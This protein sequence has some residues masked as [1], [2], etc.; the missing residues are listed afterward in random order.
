MK[1]LFTPCGI[2]MGHVSRSIA[3]SKELKKNKIETEFASYGSGYEILSEYYGYKTTKLPDIKFYGVNGELD[4]KNTVKKSIDMPYTFL[5]S[6]YQE[7]KVIK[8]FKPDLIIAD[9]QYSIPITAKIHDVPCI[10]ITNE[11]TVNFSEI[12]PNEKK[13]EYIEYGLDKFIK[14]VCNQCQMIMIPD[15]EGSTVVPLKLENKV[16]HIGPFLSKDPKK[17]GD[18]KDLKNQFGLKQSDKIVLV[19]VGGSEFGIELLKLIYS[20]SNQIKSDK[21]IIVT[22]PKLEVDFIEESEKI[23][24]KKFLQDMMEWMKI[25]DVI[26]SLAGQ[27][28]LMEIL[29]LGIPNVVV[30]IDNHP[31]QIKNSLKVGEY[32]ISIVEDIKKLNSKKL[33]HDI[34]HLLSDPKVAERSE[35]VKRIFSSYDGLK[36]VVEVIMDNL[37]SK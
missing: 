35:E 11:L 8:K 30:P 15:I 17:I 19:T 14:D 27:N 2:G 31:E 25:S 37:N 33:A 22:G 10:L 4:I 24:K 3:I 12:Y 29:S 16:L 26:V 5:K 36:K 13:V 6:I 18:K 20:A 28:T 34:N 32:G 21:I 9:S 7:S 23:M 1:V